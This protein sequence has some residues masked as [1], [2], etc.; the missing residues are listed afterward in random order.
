VPPRA[1][2]GACG[3]PAPRG[4][5][6]G[7]RDGVITDLLERVEEFIDP[8]GRLIASGEALLEVADVVR[9]DVGEQLDEPFG[10]LGELLDG[11]ATVRVG[12]QVDHGPVRV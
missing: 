10:C 3:R 4:V 6:Q 11:C 12:V 7:V 9:L 2:R 1:W 5:G 8:L